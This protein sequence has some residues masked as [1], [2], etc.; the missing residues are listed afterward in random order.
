[1]SQRRPGRVG[2]A[3]AVDPTTGMCGRRAQEESFDGCLCPPEARHRAEDELLLQ[4]SGSTVEGSSAEIVVQALE[5]E[6][7]QHPA[8]HD[9]IP[10]P[11]RMVLD[12]GLH[13]VGHSFCGGRYWKSHC[14]R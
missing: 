6:G 3:R 2:P 1:M 9:P 14:M 8:G 4:G 12:P 13:P 5:L 10:E 11:R 7:S